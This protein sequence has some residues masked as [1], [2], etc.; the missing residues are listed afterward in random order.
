VGAGLLVL[1]GVY[2]ES[3]DIY[4]ESSMQPFFDI[5]QFSD[6]KKKN[7]LSTSEE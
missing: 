4:K 3:F 5:F 7:L 1:F 2:K 6:L